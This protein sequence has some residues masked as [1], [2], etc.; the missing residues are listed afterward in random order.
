MEIV[1]RQRRGQLAD[2]TAPHEAHPPRRLARS[3]EARRLRQAGS[4][5]EHGRGEQAVRWRRTG[6]RGRGGE[7]YFFGRVTMR[8]SEDAIASGKMRLS[9]RTSAWNH[10]RYNNKLVLSSALINPPGPRAVHGGDRYD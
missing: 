9:A 5:V 1:V 8:E 7:L 10:Y 2:G 6:A 3:V 4:A